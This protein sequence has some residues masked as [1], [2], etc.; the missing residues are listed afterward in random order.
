MKEFPL[1]KVFRHRKIIKNSRGRARKGI[2]NPGA[3]KK[4]R[5]SETSTSKKGGKREANYD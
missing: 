5:G 4:R 3:K 1:N 2:D